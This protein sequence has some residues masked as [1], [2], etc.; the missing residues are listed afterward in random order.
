MDKL[1]LNTAYFPPVQYLSKIKRY[2]TVYI[3]KYEHYGKQSYRNRCE[4]MFAN[5][6]M[7]LTVPVVKATRTKVLTGEVEIDYAMNWQKIHFKS[8]ESAYKNSPFY[9]YYI[10]DLI[11]YFKRK[12][13]Y[14]IDL[15]TKIINTIFNLLPLQCDMHFTEDYLKDTTGYCDL[16]DCI[17]PK[18]SRK[19]ED[20]EFITRP[21]QQTFC[22]RYPFAPDLS[23]LDLLFNVGPE[24]T[25]YL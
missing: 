22:D 17:H 1:L 23:I 4:I 20:T 3:E 19:K 16:R 24:A 14:L 18:S 6:I 11:P 2:E 15:N 5:G 13:K 9:D 7:S 8:I 21:Y 25:D 10:D 12:E